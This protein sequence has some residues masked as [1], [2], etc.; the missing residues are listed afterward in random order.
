MRIELRISKTNY[1]WQ[2]TKCKKISLM[3][4]ML[5]VHEHPQQLNV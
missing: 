3:Q 2:I 4:N 5:R 1:E